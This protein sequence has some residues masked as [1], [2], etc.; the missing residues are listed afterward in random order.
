MKYTTEHTI[1]YDGI[2]YFCAE[3][4]GSP[5][6]CYVLKGKKGDMLID[7]GIPFIYKA[8]EECISGFDIRYIL[9]THAHVDHDSNAEKLRKSLGAEI[10]LGE[11]DRELIGHY[12]RQPVK[13]TLRRYRLRN[14]QQNICG[15]MRLFSTKPYVPDILLNSRNTGIL[16]E[17]GFDADVIMLP[18]HTLGSV[19][20]LSDGILYCGDAF[21]ALWGK[22][23]ITPHAASLNAMAR[24]LE[25]IIEISPKWLA[26]GHGL[27]VKMRDAR[28]VMK[29]YLF[30]R[31]DLLK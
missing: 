15:R 7:T 30:L 31:Q 24:S 5:V 21:T 17:L 25:R 11:R 13:A 6:T 28:S 1:K 2:H 3:I 22:P 19:G 16:R 12:G 14:V 9:L 29:K 27:P 8:L 4:M 10:L 26:C 18:G 23:D 20:V